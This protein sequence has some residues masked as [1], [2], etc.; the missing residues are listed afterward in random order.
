MANTE[1]EVAK[2]NP[3]ADMNTLRRLQGLLY[4]REKVRKTPCKR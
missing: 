2:H 3:L 4:S 1:L